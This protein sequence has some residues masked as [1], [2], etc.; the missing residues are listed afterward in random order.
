MS[1][2]QGQRQV[3]A[4]ESG[5][6]GNEYS[7]RS[8]FHKPVSR[9][10]ANPDTRESFHYEG[11]T[12]RSGENDVPSESHAVGDALP[13][14]RRQEVF[15]N[16]TRIALE[17]TSSKMRTNRRDATTPGFFLAAATR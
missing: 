16:L 6:A 13:I 12:P 10:L 5:P 9:S 2:S 14:P 15:L 11:R 1:R 7:F 4:E 8:H 3:S 17:T